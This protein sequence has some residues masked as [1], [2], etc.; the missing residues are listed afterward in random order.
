MAGMDEPAPPISAQDRSAVAAPAERL[1]A[2]LTGD[3]HCARCDYNLRGLSV[4]SACPECGCAVRA[5]I[6]A[7]VDPHAEEFRPISRPRLSAWLLVLW[8]GAALVAALCIATMRAQ[9]GLALLTGQPITPNLLPMLSIWA[10]QFSALGALALVRP[11]MDVRPLACA[12]A[13][14]GLLLYVPIL[15]IHLRILGIDAMAPNPYA[16]LGHPDAD[17]HALRAVQAVLMAMVLLALRGNYRSLVARS[18]VLR[19]GR[20][21]RQPMGPLIAA[22]AVGAAGDGM[23]AA[24]GRVTLPD[25][26]PFVAAAV[27]GLGS[28]LLIL[29]L[30]GLT[31]DTLRLRPALVERGKALRDILGAASEPEG[32][33][34]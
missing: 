23:L 33:T 26:V 28:I 31:I 21:D 14:V 30:A 29:G 9:D 8:S 6:L 34:R 15:L 5:T 3:L 19:T 2:E 27:V 12:V 17:R 16:T 1:A 4:R 10:I 25:L 32:E 22:L 24:A 18:L 20:V 11:H 13:L 7:V